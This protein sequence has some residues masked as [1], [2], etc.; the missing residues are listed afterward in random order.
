MTATTVVDGDAV[1]LTVQISGPPVPEAPALDH[2]RR[3]NGR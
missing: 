3:R 1:Q 2:F